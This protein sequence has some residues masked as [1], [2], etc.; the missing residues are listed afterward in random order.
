MDSSF[1]LAFEDLKAPIM[2]TGIASPH[3]VSK[4]E[5]VNRGICSSAESLCDLLARVEAAFLFFFSKP[6]SNLLSS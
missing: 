1:P 4:F 3:I 2:Q 6:S 5:R